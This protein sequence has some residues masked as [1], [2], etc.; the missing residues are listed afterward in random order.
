MYLQKL[1]HWVEEHIKLVEATI[2]GTIIFAC[3]LSRF[4]SPLRV[5]LFSQGFYAVII[6]ALLG[7]VLRH[8]VELRVKDQETGPKVFQDQH[9]ALQ[10]LETY[11]N[12]HHVKRADLL[13]YSTASVDSLLSALV[14]N[15]VT[16]QAN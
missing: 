7:E 16:V 4:I 9:E 10:E 1:Y 15:G 6:I 2:V 12:H 13:E 5:V 3:L 8:V 11:L 14:R